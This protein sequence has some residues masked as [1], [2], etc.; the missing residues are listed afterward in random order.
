MIL[1]H[2]RMTG[3]RTCFARPESRPLSTQK[4]H[5]FLKYMT[6]TARIAPNWMTTRNISINSALKLNLS[7]CSARIMWPVLEMGSHSV[8]PSITP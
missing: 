2:S 6:T 4:G 8:M 3:Q 7:T 1:N 5:S